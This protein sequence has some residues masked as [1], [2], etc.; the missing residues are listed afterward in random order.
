MLLKTDISKQKKPSV[1]EPKAKA[2]EKETFGTQHAIKLWRELESLIAI[3]ETT[4]Q[5]KTIIALAFFYGEQYSSEIKKRFNDKS[6]FSSK[7]PVLFVTTKQLLEVCQFANKPLQHKDL[8]KSLAFLESCGFLN[9]VPLGKIPDQT[10]SDCRDIF[11][12]SFILSPTTINQGMQARAYAIQF[13][14]K[15][16]LTQ[17]YKLPKNINEILTPLSFSVGSE[18]TCRYAKDFISLFCLS[19]NFKLVITPAKLAEKLGATEKKL[20]KQMQTYLELKMLKYIVK[21]NTNNTLLY[22]I[23]LTPNTKKP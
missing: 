22:H 15:L 8:K 4:N 19:K 17:Y 7:R 21:T 14:K 23:T 12:R 9:Y 5:V 3:A 18:N 20:Q 16:D 13:T 2:N 6:S 11:D 10:S 1:T